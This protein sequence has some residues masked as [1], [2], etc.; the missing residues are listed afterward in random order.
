MNKSM[1]LRNIGLILFGLMIVPAHAQ[2][3]PNR[4]NVLFIAVDDLKPTL[5]CYGDQL[6]NTPNIDKLAESGTVFLNNHC[7]QAV[8]G[9]SRVSIMTGMRPDHTQVWD[10]RTRMRDMNPE[11]LSMPQ[12]FKQQGYTTQGIGK[13]HDNRCV[14][15]YRDAPSWSVPYYQNS[16]TYYPK[17]TGLPEGRYQHPE[18]KKLIRKNKESSDQNES[19]WE[20]QSEFVSK[21]LRPSVESVDLPDNAY[22]DGANALHAI[23][24]L[25]QLKAEDDPFFFAVGFSKPHLPFTAPKKYWDMYERNEM[26]LAPFQKISENSPELAFHTAA[27]LHNYSDIPPITSFSDHLDGQ[28]LPIDKQKELIHG[29]Y[30]AV[31]YIDAQVGILLR[32]LDSLGMTENTIVVLWGDH[33]WHLGDHN[34]WCKHTNFEQATRSP[35]LISAPGIDPS[36]TK[37]PTEFVDVFPTLC[38]LAGI[39]IPS[40]LDGESL[41]PLMK[42]PEL[43]LKEFAVSQ[44][45]RTDNKL[46]TGG[47]GHSTGQIMGYSIRTNRYRY[48][49]WMG[50]DFKSTQPY[51]EDLVVATELYDYE[52]DPME[53]VNFANEDTYSK[54]RHEMDKLM[55]SYFQ[56]QVI[57]GI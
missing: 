13:V 28:G 35:L 44:F 32:T 8:C 53:T 52:K 31:S 6:A 33:G 16:N 54:I 17:S 29:Y 7:Q 15:E 22:V 23:D 20:K 3:Q 14:D 50:N 18:T 55:S 47:L 9:P 19:G 24:I 46:E 34:L 11:I 21:Y 5:G 4:P 51:D 40:H 42:E 36:K 41:V 26:P 39:V 37:S 2:D 30:A 10:L 27:E 43:M 1:L 56:S 57:E 49:V 38:N 48:T 12:Y 25:K 45:P